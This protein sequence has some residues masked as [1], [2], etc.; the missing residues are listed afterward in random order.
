MRKVTTE[1]SF[2]LQQK[3][4]KQ[5]EGGSL[6]VNLGDIQMIRTENDVVKPLKPGFY[7]GYFDDIYS[8]IHISPI[9]G[10]FCTVS[11]DLIP[12]D[13]VNSLNSEYPEDSETR[14]KYMHLLLHSVINPIHDLYRFAS[15]LL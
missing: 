11:F 13:D 3:L 15:H 6:S 14:Y 9:Q 5:P 8:R 4:C 2:Q 12:L 10:A 7:K 1:C